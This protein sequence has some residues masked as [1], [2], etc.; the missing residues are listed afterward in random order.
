MLPAVKPFSI[1]AASSVRRSSNG[2]PSHPIRLIVREMGLRTQQRPAAGVM[3]RHTAGRCAISAPASV[4]P[5]IRLAPYPTL[6]IFR[7]PR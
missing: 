2:G 6:S 4:E 1:L 7:H 5:P 3:N